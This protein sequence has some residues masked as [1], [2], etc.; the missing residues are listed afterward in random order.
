MLFVFFDLVIVRV[1][2]LVM[3]I[4]FLDRYVDWITWSGKC[5]EEVERIGSFYYYCIF[6]FWFRV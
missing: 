6:S 1:S 4:V 3:D 2:S 5:S